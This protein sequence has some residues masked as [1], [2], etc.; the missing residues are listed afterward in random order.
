MDMW[1]FMEGSAAAAETVGIRATLV[2][3]VAD[4]EFD[5]FETI[6]SNRRLLETHRTAADGRVRT[7]VGLEHLFYCSEACFRDGAR[8][9][10]GVRHRA[11]HP[12]VGVDLGGRRSR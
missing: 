1:R 5:Y 11:P 8:T 10:R 4:G 7:W 12:L 2:P 6:E 9:G 3:Y